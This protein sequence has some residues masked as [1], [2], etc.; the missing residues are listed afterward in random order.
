MKMQKMVTRGRLAWLLSLVLVGVPMSMGIDIHRASA[1]P[2]NST[3]NGT[4]YFIYVPD[5]YGVGQTAYDKGNHFPVFTGG[6]RRIIILDFGREW[7]N[8]TTGNWGISLIHTDPGIQHSMNWVIS[9]AQAFID[10]YNHN[11]AHGFA[12]IGISTNTSNFH[13]DCNDADLSW[14][15]AGLQWGIMMNGLTNRPRAGV[16]SANDIETWDHENWPPPNQEWSACGAGVRDWFYGYMSQSTITNYNFGDNPN[17]KIP[18][19]WSIPD[20]WLVSWGFPPALVLPQIYC[21]GDGWAA[22][23]PS[24]R[25]YN[26]MIFSGI[27]SDNQQ[28]PNT[29]GAGVTSLTWQAAWGGPYGLN[30]ALTNHGY[31][32]IVESSAISPRSP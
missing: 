28:G 6:G 14:L 22:S 23:W 19:R 27:S 16:Y 31:P 21:T 13:W 8:P 15:A 11:Q 12:R 3:P 30:T 4:G 29:C 26:P 24:I 25:Q 9:V 18:E 2:L 1:D 17:N 7:Q 32:N 20:V 10:G 5:V